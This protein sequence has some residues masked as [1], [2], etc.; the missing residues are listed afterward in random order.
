MRPAAMNTRNKLDLTVA[1]NAGRRLVGS[2]QGRAGRW[3]WVWNREKRRGGQDGREAGAL[4]VFI[5]VVVV[6]GSVVGEGERVG[7]HG[8][9]DVAGLLDG[10]IW[11]YCFSA[12]S[13]PHPAQGALAAAAAASM[14]IS[15]LPLGDGGGGGDPF[16]ELSG[17]RGGG[18]GGGAAFTA[19]GA[20]GQAVVDS[21]DGEAGVGAAAGRGRHPQLVHGDLVLSLSD[22][23]LD[24][25]QLIGQLL[26]LGRRLLRPPLRT[27]STK[28]RQSRKRPLTVVR[29]SVH[30]T[31]TGPGSFICCFEI[32]TL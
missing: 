25:L 3:V 15:D 13:N 14:A 27:A 9:N 12:S 17:R 8:R 28:R 7:R 31:R 18:D 22:R 4:V 19:C 11:R 21:I 24:H 6:A 30:C 23:G 16:G 29:R 10:W 2:G 20:P 1:G 32:V 5:R 26:F